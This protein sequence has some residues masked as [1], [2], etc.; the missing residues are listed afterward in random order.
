MTIRSAR[1]ELASMPRDESRC[2]G[3]L[4][5]AL[6]ASFNYCR[7]YPRKLALLKATIKYVYVQIVEL[8]KALEAAEE[9]AKE[10]AEQ[11][12]KEQAEAAKLAAEE[13]AKLKLQQENGE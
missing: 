6:C 13:E 7:R 3:G 11:L 2:L 9:E 1:L 4:R 12:A 5:Q 10:K 8:E